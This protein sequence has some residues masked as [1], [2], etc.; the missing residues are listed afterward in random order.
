M[1]RKPNQVDLSAGAGRDIECGECGEPTTFSPLAMYFAKRAQAVCKR[2]GWAPIKFREVALC[3]DC[4]D[5][6]VEQNRERT[7]RELRKETE[8][9]K[10]KKRANADAD[11]RAFFEALD[12]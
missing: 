5:V 10:T 12:G 11:V 8:Q 7:R 1:N 4:L 2:K 6:W 3:S 9:M